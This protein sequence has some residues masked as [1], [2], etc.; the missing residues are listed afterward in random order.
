MKVSPAP[1]R[2]II[3]ENVLILPRVFLETVLFIHS[4]IYSFSIFAECLL[5]ARPCILDLCPVHMVTASRL[6]V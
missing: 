4:L 3:M 5:R 6:W 2:D 1:L